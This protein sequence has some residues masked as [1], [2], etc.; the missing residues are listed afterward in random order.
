MSLMILIWQ[1]SLTSLTSNT[2]SNPCH[3]VST[4]IS[5]VALWYVSLSNAIMLR[6]R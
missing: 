2:Q 5:L 6:E 1:H 3:A 4:C